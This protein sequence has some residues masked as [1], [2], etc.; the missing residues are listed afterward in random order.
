MKKAVCNKCKYEFNITLRKEK[1]KIRN[2]AERVYFICPKCKEEYT[3]YFTN[4][5]IKAK[6]VKI[7]RLKKEVENEM[8][9]LQSDLIMEEQ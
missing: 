4:D 3:A 1:L 2:N 7:E 8:N 6:Q 9:S 5:I